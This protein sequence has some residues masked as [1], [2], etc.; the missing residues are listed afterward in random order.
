MAYAIVKNG[1]FEKWFQDENIIWSDT[2]FQ[3]AASLTPE[4]Q[5]EFGIVPFAFTVPPPYNPV[6]QAAPTEN[7]ALL[8]NG[9]WTQQWNAPA[10]LPADVA[11]SNQQIQQTQIIAS[12]ESAVQSML[13]AF[14]QSWQY[15]SIL[16]AASYS[17]S[18]VTK[19]QHE[20][21][22]LIA[23]RD[24]VWSAC[25]TSMVAIQGGT[26]AM[27]VSPAAFIATLPAS[28]SRPI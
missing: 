28:P 5:I 8:V 27:P 24:Q 6:T 11:A 22:V 18:T 12:Y 26:M 25:Y 23:W 20:A 4:Q 7:G 15:E 3:A 10:T 9:I 16:S 19:F 1:V 13:D 17:A 2:V 14:A 21:N